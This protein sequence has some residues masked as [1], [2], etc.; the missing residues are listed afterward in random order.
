MPSPDRSR[1]PAADHGKRRAIAVSTASLPGF[2][3]AELLIVLGILGILAAL[4]I[5]AINPTKQ[6]GGATDASR[7]Y[8]ARELENAEFQYLIDHGT[9]AADKPIPDGQGHALPVCRVGQTDAG[10]VNLDALIPTY[11]PC[12]P[13][14]GAETNPAYSGYQ[15]HQDV[16]RPRATAA[17]VGSGSVQGGCEALSFLSDGLIGYWKLDETS[18]PSAADSSG[19]GDT[20]TYAPV[21]TI[22]TNVPP[23]SFADARSLSFTGTDGYVNVGTNASLNLTSDLT[24]AA[25]VNNTNADTVFRNIITKFGGCSNASAT[26]L[27]A[28]T[29]AGK[30]Q[31]VVG[32]VI[33]TATST[34]ALNDGAWHHVAA[35]I[36]GTTITLYVDGVADSTTGTTSARPSNPSTQTWIGDIQPCP[37][38]TSWKGLLDDVRIYNRALSTSEV[39]QLAAGTDVSSSLVGYWKFDETSGTTAAD[40]S[41]AGNNGTQSTGPT[42]STDVPTTRFTNARSLSFDGV[43]NHVSLADDPLDF[44]TSNYSVSVWIKTS[45]LTD[46][47]VVSKDPGGGGGYGIWLSSAGKAYFVSRAS[48]SKYKDTGVSTT[49]VADGNWHHIVGAR[50][51][52]TLTLW[53]DGVQEN[54]NTGVSG[55][56]S[57][58]QTATIGTWHSSLYPFAGKVD[59]VRLYNRALS[60]SEIADIAAGRR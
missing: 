32:G 21:L 26:Y 48:V 23:T 45:V 4:V 51:G 1:R 41:G 8:T 40:S 10:C 12:I 24:V 39:S 43:S 57:N 6:L 58:A 28:K 7:R 50:N 11:L 34:P 49:V 59:D 56:T 36:S 35:R 3:L 20:G 30:L 47:A 46:M 2:T 60:A 33:T 44:G 55:S 13:Y 27:L 14:D 15:L 18:G 38:T 53:I 9:Y 5:I 19:F 16:G 29:T 42:P 37:G 17:Y 52:G 54:S 25:W 31:F 22:S